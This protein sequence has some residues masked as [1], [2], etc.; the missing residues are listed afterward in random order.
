MSIDENT[1]QI[2]W[3][4]TGGDSLFQNTS[5]NDI[6]YNPQY[7][8]LF[9]SKDSPFTI[10]CVDDGVNTRKCVCLAGSG[11]FIQEHAARWLRHNGMRYDAVSYHPDCGACRAYVEQ[12]NME[13]DPYL[14]GK[15]WAQELAKQLNVDYIEVPEEQMTRPIG[16]HDARGLIIDGSARI[17]A[18]KYRKTLPPMFTCSYGAFPKEAQGYLLQEIEMICGIAFGPH[19]F[20]EKFTAETPFYVWIIG[21][22]EIEFCNE[23]TLLQNIKPVLDKY[24]AR[25]AISSATL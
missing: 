2:L 19:G 16:F 7:Q 14:V 12:N 3:E 9:A 5:L 18:H 13:D 22:N 6:L 24:S 10:V 23:Q 20:S 21:N 8:N 11:I 25:I 4:Q 15:K 17:Q 1:I